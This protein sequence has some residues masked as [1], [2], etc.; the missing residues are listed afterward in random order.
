MSLTDA[1]SPVKPGRAPFRPLKAAPQAT[2]WTDEAGAVHVLLSSRRQADAYELVPIATDFGGAAFR[3][4][5]RGGECYDVLC[6]GDQSSCSCAGWA[7]TGS[8][9]H[10]HWTFALLEAGVLTPAPGASPEPQGD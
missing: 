2:Y 4:F 3:W 5:K 1:I 10:V 6:C 9:K 8:C 7:Y